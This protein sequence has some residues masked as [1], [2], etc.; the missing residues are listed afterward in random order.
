M[1]ILI[2][3]ANGFE[4]TEAIVPAD[5]LRRAGADVRLVSVESAKEVTGSH[6][7]KVAAD[8]LITEADGKGIAALVLPGGGPGTERLAASPEVKGLIELAVKEGAY[9]CAICAAPSVL[10]RMG[11]LDG[12]KFACYPGFE[13]YMPQAVKTGKRVETDGKFITAECMGVSMEFALKI[14]EILFGT[15][16][17]EEVEGKINGKS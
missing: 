8:A 4:E 13:K 5:V 2:L 7:I 12:R 17:R 11:L 1:K 15:E 9:I 16:K 14:S 10:G 3:L 6:G